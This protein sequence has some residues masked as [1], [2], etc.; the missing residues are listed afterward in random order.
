MRH[1]NAHARA[2]L[3]LTGRLDP[4]AL[5]AFRAD[6]TRSPLG[7]PAS[8]PTW[9]RLLDGT[10]AAI[11]LDRLGDPDVA[12][13][14][15]AVLDGPLRLR[16]GRRHSAVHVPTLLRLTT[17]V[18]WEHAAATAL[19]RTCGWIGDGDWDVLRRPG[20]GAAAR[21][22]RR[23]EDARLVA[24]TRIWAQLLGDAEAITILSRPT[25]STDPIAV[26]LDAVHD[27]VRTAAAPPAAG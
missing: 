8:E 17:A 20:L 2:A 16:H 24:A 19:A 10:L 25:R 18:T 3:A 9:V 23:I 7:V 5:A 21:G 27:R 26:S 13:R 14:W 1:D 4:G 15:Q 12:R 11:A 22:G 6:G